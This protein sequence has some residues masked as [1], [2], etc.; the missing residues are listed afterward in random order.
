MAKHRYLTKHS[1]EEEAFGILKS[2]FSKKFS[3]PEYN[4]RKLTIIKT[5]NGYLRVMITA[6]ILSQLWMVTILEIY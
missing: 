4:A 5:G 3:N 2:T 6:I 1:P